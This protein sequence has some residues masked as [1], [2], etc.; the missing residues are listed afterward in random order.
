MTG[1]DGEANHGHTE[2]LTSRLGRDGQ[3]HVGTGKGRADEP[4]SLSL[5]AQSGVGPFLDPASSRGISGATGPLQ[6]SPSVPIAMLGS[7]GLV[8]EHVVSDAPCQNQRLYRAIDVHVQPSPIRRVLLRV[9]E[10][11]VSATARPLRSAPSAGAWLPGISPRALPIGAQVPV[12][13]P[14]GQLLVQPGLDEGSHLGL[15]RQRELVLRDEELAAHSGESVLHQG[16][17]L[18]GAEEDADRWVVSGGHLVLAEPA[19]I[20][21]ELTQVLV[22]EAVALELDEDMALEDAVIEDQVHEE[23]LAAD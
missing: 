5:T 13:C 14:L 15:V 11:V 22:G 4:P 17:V 23:V 12:V 3:V 10:S 7:D 1:R 2:R 16:V 9:F 8:A 6:D 21:V 20:G 18:L 19:H